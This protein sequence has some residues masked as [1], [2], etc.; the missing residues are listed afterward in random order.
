MG[1]V[2]REAASVFRKFGYDV[3]RLTSRDEWKW[4]SHVRPI[5]ARRNTQTYDDARA[6]AEKY[7]TPV[8]GP[9][10][11]WD[12]LERLALCV[13]EVDQRLGLVS[14]LV[15]TLQVADGMLADGIDDPDLI[16]AAL[17]HD[18]GKVLLLV[19]EDPANVGGPTAVLSAPGAG[20]GLDQCTLQ[21]GADEFA[22]ARLKDHVPDHVGWLIRYH[23]IDIAAERPFMDARDERYV[24]EYLTLFQR[25]DEP[26]KSWSQL[27]TRRLEDFRD[28]IDAWFPEPILF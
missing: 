27:P 17:F 9:V 12:A 22:Y 26:T 25:Y 11:S 28:L 13:D 14:Q 21:W 4:A 8:F 16:I 24:D 2:K 23:S 6:L 5:I 19:G 15:H 18:V 3:Q 7:Q 1:V 20:V 10:M